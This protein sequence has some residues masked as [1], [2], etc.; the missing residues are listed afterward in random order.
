MESEGSSKLNFKL[1]RSL[2]FTDLRLKTIESFVSPLKE[3]HEFFGKINWL[4]EVSNTTSFIV[5]N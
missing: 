2:A 5:I 4:Y 3:T 1:P